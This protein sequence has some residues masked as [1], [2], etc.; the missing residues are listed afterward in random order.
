MID[1]EIVHKVR[2]SICAVGYSTIPVQ[3]LIKDVRRPFFKVIGSGFVIDDYIAMTN[4][5]VIEGVLQ[6]QAE[7]GFPDE[8]RALLFVYPANGDELRISIAIMS[9]FGFLDHEDF[10]VGFIDFV[11][12]KDK[13]FQKVKPLPIQESHQYAVSEEIA[14]CGYPY[15]HAMLHKKAKVYRWGPV[16][17]RGF[18]SAISP[19]DIVDEPNEILL[20][21]RVAGG[22]SGAPI[23]RP[24]DGTVIGLLH[25]GW[26]ATTALGQPLS[27]KLIQT[28]L[29]MHKA[30]RDKAE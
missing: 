22:M 10:D 30:G 3:E 8:H 12:P 4:R 1:Q 28:W 24:S 23:F 15:G 7:I 29:R 2:N 25:S 5:H 14:V 26:E 17:Q 18:L 21:V 13:Y 9:F 16:L 19:F 27:K 6:A 20:D 11:K